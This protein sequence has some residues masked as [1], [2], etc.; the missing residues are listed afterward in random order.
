M[1]HVNL[2]L[3]GSALQHGFCGC[4]IQLN[5][6]CPLGNLAI[7]TLP[8][9]QGIF[10]LHKEQVYA[11]VTSNCSTSQLS[12]SDSILNGAIVQFTSD[13]EEEV[14]CPS[15]PNQFVTMISRM[16]PSPKLLIFN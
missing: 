14:I 15:G 7:G 1:S 12:P 13:T 6:F 8:N 16:T 3:P 10:T 2:A 9:N 5:D 4:S 11:S